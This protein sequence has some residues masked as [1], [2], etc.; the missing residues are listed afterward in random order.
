MN[1]KAIIISG[2]ITFLIIAYLGYD[3][4]VYYAGEKTC[5]AF[6]K[7]YLNKTQKYIFNGSIYGMPVIA[8]STIRFYTPEVYVRVKDRLLWS[9]AERNLVI[10]LLISSY[11]LLSYIVVL[12]VIGM[13]MNYDI[14]IVNIWA[15]LVLFYLQC[16]VIFYVSY[17]LTARY[18]LS[19]FIPIIVNLT[20]VMI[21]IVIEY[22]SKGLNE[23]HSLIIFAAYEIISLTIGFAMLYVI[24]KGK[25]DYILAVRSDC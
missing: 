4:M 8:A 21:M 9:I 25:R 2:V 17:F 22:V 15:R 12:C 11:V 18:L 16:S 24:Q 14:G 13:G 20:M 23:G 3:F 7:I 19:V 10:S 6:I 5:D 1:R